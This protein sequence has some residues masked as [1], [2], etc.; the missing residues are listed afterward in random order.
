M[1][2]FK[3]QVTVKVLLCKYRINGDIVYALVYFNSA[4]NAVINSDKYG[5]VKSFQEI[6]YRIDYWI[7]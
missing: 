1:K 3:Y 7:E 4:V 5:L 6:L 2:S